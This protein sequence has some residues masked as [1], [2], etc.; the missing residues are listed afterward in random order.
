MR[1]LKKWTEENQTRRKLG[2]GGRNSTIAEDDK[3]LI[4]MAVTDRTAS[5]RVLAQRWITATSMPY[6]A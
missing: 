4:R 5:S 3:R 2:S 6:H 1:I